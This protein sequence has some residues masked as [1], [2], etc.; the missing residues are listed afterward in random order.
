MECRLTDVAG[1][2]APL[3]TFVCSAVP[4]HGF[5]PLVGQAQSEAPKPTV[6]VYRE[7]GV[8]LIAA[9]RKRQVEAEGRTSAHDDEHD[10]G[11][12]ANAAVTYA[13]QAY[14]GATAPLP[15]NDRW[16]W[17]EEWWKPS[18]PIRMLVKA[19]ALIAAEIDRRLRK[20]ERP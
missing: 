7:D 13:K 18:S 6:Q 17:D 2:A 19:G 20:G 11:E 14:I 12:L 4:Q 1:R 5:G 3:M 8:A 10:S 16:P 9:E 15:A